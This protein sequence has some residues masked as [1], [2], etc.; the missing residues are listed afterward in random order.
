MSA[1]LSKR[2]LVWVEKSS[3]DTADGAVVGSY[4][5]D[6]SKLFVVRA[7]L[8]DELSHGML[9]I[10]DDCG[11]FP[12]FGKELKSN[13]Y[14]VLVNNGNVNLTW[15]KASRGHVPTGAVIGGLDHKKRLIHIARC[16]HSGDVVPGKL[17]ARWG[18][19][20]IPCD[21]KEE[22]HSFYEV[23]CVESIYADSE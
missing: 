6:G 20:F 8:E 12:Y 3:G 10:G 14:E 7:Q 18:M 22:R 5:K 13:K 2:G 9:H 1:S 23:L 21:G 17:V 16:D 15:V 19:A 4:A 11:L